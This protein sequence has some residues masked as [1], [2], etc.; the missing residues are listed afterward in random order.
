VVVEQDFTS[1]EAIVDAGPDA[2]QPIYP[3]QGLDNLLLVNRLARAGDVMLH[4][5]GV[6]V[7]G[8]G[9]C[10]AGSSGAGKSTLARHLYKTHAVTV[11]GEDQV[12]LRYLDGRFW[13]YGTPWHDEPALCSPERAPLA[14][15]FFL[16]RSAAP[17][18]GAMTAI[19]S[20]VWLM[21]TAFIPYYR[22][23]GVARILDRLASL[24][25]RVPFYRLSYQLGADVLPL[26]TD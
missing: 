15:L 17:G 4:A 21:K 5:S 16:D 20:V 1:G 2:G 10:F 7:E 3:L 14:K 25:E 9:Y 23:Q 22:P 12:I 19:D 24:A 8:Q 11:L 26:I 13:I 6:T 18:V